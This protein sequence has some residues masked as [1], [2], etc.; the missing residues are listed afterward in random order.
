MSNNLQWRE[1]AAAQN[2]KEV[3]I[4]E[5]QSILDA[6][7][8]DKLDLSGGGSFILTA[9]QFTQHMTFKFS[10]VSDVTIPN[11]K[12]FFILDNRDGTDTLEVTKGATTLEV[13]A[14]VALSFYSSGDVDTVTVVTN[15]TVEVQQYE[16]SAFAPGL[17]GANELLMAVV[18][19][20]D[21]NFRLNMP[22]AQAVA[23]TAAT[24]PSAYSFD[25]QKNGVSVG[26][27]EFVAANP[28][29]SFQTAAFAVTSGDVIQIFGS[30]TPDASLADVAF[31]LVGDFA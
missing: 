9:E 5:Q 25:V 6:A 11:I 20:R 27:V 4:N 15:F 17:P 22:G 3:T 7:L 30:G 16:V 1:V 21:A 2:Q 19:N 24:G 31:T 10:D 28:E 23:Q 18:A 12:K 29:G 26:T 14:G 13:P 8:S